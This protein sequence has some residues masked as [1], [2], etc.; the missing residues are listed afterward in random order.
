MNSFDELV[1]ILRPYGE[2]IVSLYKKCEFTIAGITFNFWQ[3]LLW[4]VIAVFLID[5]IR[6][7]VDE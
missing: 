2:T 7:L 4:S 1:E 6:D 5:R 3:L